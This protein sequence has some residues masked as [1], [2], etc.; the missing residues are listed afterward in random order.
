MKK[1]VRFMLGIE[2]VAW[3]FKW[4][5]EPKYCKVC[6][7]NDCGGNV[8]DRKSTS[9]GIGRRGAHVVKHW[10]TTQKTIALSSGEAEL[11]A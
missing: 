2:K 5:D 11:G 4:Q 8:R 1:L 10:A 7:D 3:E 9:G 6:S